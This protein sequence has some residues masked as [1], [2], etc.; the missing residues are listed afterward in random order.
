MKGKKVD[1]KKQII[2][3]VYDALENL[4][5]ERPADN[6]VPVAMDTLLLAEGGLVDSLE[7]VSL[8]VDVEVA[9]AEKFQCA[10]SLTD[11]EA[12]SRE[13][14]PFHDVASLCDY[15]S[16]VVQRNATAAR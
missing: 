5:A 3:I 1:Q 4:N 10:T 16:E 11:D 6:K 9:M 15:I 12:M 8:I 2:N 7:L 14:S 13:E